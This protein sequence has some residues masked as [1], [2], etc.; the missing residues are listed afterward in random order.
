MFKM[1]HLISSGDMTTNSCSK[2]QLG[3]RLMAA[4]H[5]FQR[6]DHCYKETIGKLLR[7]SYRLKSSGLTLD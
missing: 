3:N 1:K 2:K 7:I 6:N 4:N 5:G